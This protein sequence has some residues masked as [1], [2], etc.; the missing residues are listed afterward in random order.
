MSC[1]RTQHSDAGEQRLGPQAP[2]SRVK[3]S[4]TEPL[5]SRKVCIKKW[6]KVFIIIPE[7]KILRLTFCRKFAEKSGIRQ[8]IIASLS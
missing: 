2:H 4:T 8:I 3:H 7:L 1:S 6:M 5:R